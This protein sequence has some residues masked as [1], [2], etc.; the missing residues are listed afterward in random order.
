MAA[1]KRMI[2]PFEPGQVKDFQGKKIVSYGT[3]SYGYDVRCSTEF[4]IFTNINSTIVDPKHFDEA[5]RAHYA[6]LYALPGAMHSGFSQFAAF[7][8]DAI[9]N[10]KFLESS[11]L[12][13]PVLAIGGEKSFGT[14]M[15]TVMRSGASD[16][17]EAV[18]PDSGHWIMEENPTATIALVKPFLGDG[19]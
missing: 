14:M 19:K 9:D 16:V 15:A 4:K 11:K 8:Q 18:V 13:M 12:A 3:S 10:R 6:A 2:E 1:E 17:Q 5:S 7:D